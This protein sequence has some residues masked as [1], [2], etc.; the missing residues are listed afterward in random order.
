MSPGISHTK[1]LE[2]G[3]FSFKTASCTIQCMLSFTFQTQKTDAFFKITLCISLLFNTILF[4]M[5]NIYSV[6]ALHILLC[7]CLKHTAGFQ[8][9]SFFFVSNIIILIWI[10]AQLGNNKTR[11]FIHMPQAYI[12]GLTLHTLKTALSSTFVLQRFC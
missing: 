8:H 7:Y 4:S 5:T 12:R 11:Y 9:K 10:F 2:I 3:N 6:R 1:K